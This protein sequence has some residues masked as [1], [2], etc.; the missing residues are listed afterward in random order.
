[1]PFGPPR[2]VC[3]SPDERPGGR[4]GRHS[5]SRL[6]PSQE[7]MDEFLFL[8]KRYSAQFRMC[9]ENDTGL[10][11]AKFDIEQAHHVPLK[12]LNREIGG[13]FDGT[14]FLAPHGWSASIMQALESFRSGEWVYHPSRFCDWTPIESGQDMGKRERVFNPEKAR[15]SLEWLDRFI[16]TFEAELS[17]VTVPATD[18]QRESDRQ[19]ITTLREVGRRCTTKKL[20]DEMTKRELNPAESTVKKRLAAMVTSGLLTNDAK[21]KPPGY[22]LPEWSRGSSGS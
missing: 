4:F 3:S 18:V 12:A 9:V 20:L 1:R 5:M 22:G 2:V 13:L 17:A 11:G 15:I 7:A 14:G 16:K 10:R 6:I 19:I 8:L 21:A